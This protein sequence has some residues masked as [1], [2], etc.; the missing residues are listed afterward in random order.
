MGL[1]KTTKLDNGMVGF[2][3]IYGGMEAPFGGIDASNT[4]PR[5]ID[6][7]CFA[8]ASNFLIINNELC[9]HTLVSVYIPTP[10][11]IPSAGAF[12][13]PISST[14]ASAI[15][16]CVLLGVGKLPCEDVVK[17]W[18]LY[19][20]AAADS[21]NYWYYRLILW[22]NDFS[23]IP[24]ESYD[25]S[26]LGQQIVSS[27]TPATASI[28][29]SYA[30]GNTQPKHTTLSP[31]WG[32]GVHSVP[33]VVSGGSTVYTAV[34]NDPTYGQVYWD[35][36]YLKSSVGGVPLDGH[37]PPTTGYSP[38]MDTL[39][40]GRAWTAKNPTIPTGATVI[41]N[42]ADIA[43]AFLAA[44]TYNTG[45]SYYRYPFT[46]ALDPGDNTRIILTAATGTGLPDVSGSKGNSISLSLNGPELDP[47][48]FMFGYINAALFYG[49]VLT[50]VAAQDV[51][52]GA[53]G[54][55]N[56]T[57]AALVPSAY[58][59]TITPFSGGT[60][61]GQ[62]LYTNQAIQE[63]TYETIG[64]R[65]FFSGWPAG[66]MLQ[67]NNTTKQFGSLTTYEGARVLKKMA[68]HLISVGLIPG[69]DPNAG[70]A[71]VQ[72]TDEHLWFSWSAEGRYE[73]WY[74]VFPPT[75]QPP[76]TPG[77]VTGAGG[78]Q[79]I[80]ISDMLTGIIVSNS[81]VFILRAEG[82][83]YATVQ[84]NA[85]LPFDVSHVDLCKDG[86]GCPSTALWTQF[87]QL[88][89]YVGMTN[90]FM[91]QQSPQAIG[92]KIICTLFP[93]LF[94]M[95]NRLTDSPSSIYNLIGD[96]PPFKDIYYN[97]VS[98]EPLTFTSNM[99]ENTAFA[100]S[101]NSIIFMFSPLDGT[102]MKLNCD[103]VLPP[104][105]STTTWSILKII[106]LPLWSTMG[107]NGSYQT[108][109]ALIYGQQLDASGN[110]HIPVMYNLSP[111][112]YSTTTQSAHVWF[113]A[114]EISFGRDI[115]IDALYVLASGAPGLEIDFQID[116]W[117]KD[118][119]GNFSFISAAFT[120]KLIFD[121]SAVPGLY[122]E[123]QI[124]DIATGGAVT[125]KAPQLKMNVNPQ[126]SWGGYTPIVAYPVSS[127][128]YIKVAKV[129][130][131]G[132]FDPNQR[133]V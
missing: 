122:Q 37:L 82:L 51:V 35:M 77:T 74:A 116:G 125:M 120:G 110:Y 1:L 11:Q 78:E 98:V 34:Y 52:A 28:K 105:T 101:L 19:V 113:P 57:P 53:S 50:T 12:T 17:N 10:D 24:V 129:A 79:L 32:Q 58:I 49:Y 73:V 39:V 14:G 119:N 36:P 109:Q 18:A 7:K 25:C 65:L 3:C 118:Q 68:G 59:V 130:M 9:I 95:S 8:D 106:S 102:W 97:K 90:I 83:S 93:L 126:S 87:D 112:F 21:N 6:P 45:T 76:D 91:L 85:S 20:S 16:P 63:L 23:S 117:Q 27:G 128:P 104:E 81:V 44:F 114:E 60:D 111:R 33:P 29:F 80:D 61:S 2:E 22:R 31:I 88:G 30:A 43:Q 26:I 67:F 71:P 89:F 42:L 38:R 40:A 72:I 15:N 69:L 75:A 48:G 96:P 13:Y 64:D 103:P 54:N 107:Y 92:D 4:N 5:Y 133:P 56:P 46:V 131:F 47:G 41:P 86:Q 132:S 84:S 94:N 108:K 123:Y 124:F 100:I 127:Q 62:V 55:Y 70:N 121:S 115:T 66:Y 99:K